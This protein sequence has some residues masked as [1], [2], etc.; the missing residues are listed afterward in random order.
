MRD[1]TPETISDAFADYAATPT[2][3]RGRDVVVALARHL[4]AW[5]REVDLT[6]DEWRA[7]LAALTRAGEITT[8]ERN[9]FVLFS[10]MFGLSSLVDMINS[11][12]GSTSASVLGP[13]HQL[14]APPIPNGGDLWRGQPG[15]VVLIEG[16]VI[17]AH[18]GDA[19]P[20][21][22]L[23]LWQNADNGLYSAQ[24][25][26][27]PPKNYHALLHADAAGRFC[28]TTTRFR[29][30]MVPQDGPAGDM[31]RLLGREAWRAAHLHLVVE[32]P[33]YRS[34]VTELFPSDDERLDRDAAFGVRTDLLLDL[35]PATPGD[36]D[37]PANLAAR[38]S[39][40]EHFIRGRATIK[41]APG[42][43]QVS[44][45]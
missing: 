15:E 5:A 2:D 6:H 45:L 23:D 40:P 24:D 33:G 19:I 25:P 31:L 41:L 7:G 37:L 21:A 29:P 35:R 22:S 20:H 16:S 44:P 18:T 28:F 30:Y 13:F 8:P 36:N 11:P 10:D 3:Q 38:A 32:A 14:G 34:I 4:H 26:N 9:E 12:P 27:Q 1:T 39:L 43:N 17:D 42:T